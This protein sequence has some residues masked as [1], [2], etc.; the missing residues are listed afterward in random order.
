MNPVE[1]PLR[2][3][4]QLAFTLAV[5]LFGTLN[6]VVVGHLAYEALRV[7]QDRRL[8]FVARL[9]AQ[10]V[11]RPLLV[12][13]RLGLQKLIE[14]SRNLDP[15][16]AYVVVRSRDGSTQAVSA[17]KDA[18]ENLKQPG[19]E[20]DAHAYRQVSAG[21]LE[22]RLGD[23][24]VG[25]D[26]ESL[27]RPL[28]S[29]V[30]AIAAMVL[31]F[32]AAGFV[33]AVFVAQSVTRPVNSLVRFTSDFRLDSPLPSLAVETRDELAQL[34]EQLGSQAKRLQEFH[35]EARTRERQLARVEH[36]ATVGR[37]AAGV[38]HEIRNP[39]AGIRSGLERLL[40][41]S[42]DGE[43]SR[44]YATVLREAISRIE[45]TVQGTLDFARASEVTV[46][47]VDLAEVLERALVLA[48]PQL[49]QNRVG[50]VRDVP[51]CLPQVAADRARLQ[52]VLLN[53]ILNACDA[54]PGGGELRIVAQPA[55][56]EVWMEMSDTG[57][58]VP[59][60]AA[61]R[62]FEPFFTTKPM[63]KGTGLGLAVSRAA[64]REMGGDLE[65]VAGVGSTSGATFRL[66]LTAQGGT[67]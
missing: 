29:V 47:T 52:Q 28:A 41:L 51:A 38:A 64:V 15:D 46:E 44:R 12:D 34:A 7:E 26:E 40:R 21:I 16:L 25:V 62:L 17:Y 35:A 43:D 5:V 42:G 9:L 39:L 13:D 27:R 24:F 50:L 58:G 66:R 60:E 19:S 59:A 23:V 33:G 31:V 65:L 37:L 10:R 6:I 57:P 32:L 3:R 55:G 54:M 22:G 2:A 53:L 20:R 18:A 11:T 30:Y 8:D 4:L 63:G 48:A 61:G 36:L 56:K 67:A 45:R 49:E 1:R 14:E